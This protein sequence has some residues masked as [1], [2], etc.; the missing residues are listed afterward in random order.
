MNETSI[1]YST[2]REIGD[3]SSSTAALD[4]Y[5]ES[6]RMDV[7]RCRSDNFDQ[8]IIHRAKILLDSIEGAT[9]KAISGRNTE[10]VIKMFGQTLC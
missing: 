4:E 8:H 6:H 9:G 5:L 2:N 1:T 7:D 3:V 10:D